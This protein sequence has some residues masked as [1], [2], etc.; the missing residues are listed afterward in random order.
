M[1]PR[2]RYR[3]RIDASSRNGKIRGLVHVRDGH[4]FTWTTESDNLFD[5]DEFN[6]I[7][8]RIS[9]WFKKPEDSLRAAINNQV[10]AFEAEAGRDDPRPAPFAKHD[11]HARYYIERLRGQGRFVRAGDSTFFF[12]AETRMPVNVQAGDMLGV[13]AGK[14]P[15]LNETL[16]VTK[17]VL[18]E[19]KWLPTGGL[20]EVELRRHSHYDPLK[21]ELVLDMGAGRVLKV[22]G[23][24]SPQVI[25]NGTEG[26]MFRPGALEEPW[27]YKPDH[28]VVLR[29][30][31]I[32][33]LNFSELED[34]PFTMEEQRFL[35]L[36]WMLSFWFRSTMPA[37]PLIV[38]Y[39]HSGSGK[40]LAMEHV[41]KL[42]IGPKFSTNPPPN[43]DDKTKI[44]VALVNRVFLVID[45]LDSYVKWFQDLVS[46]VVTGS[47]LAD[48]LLYENMKE[49][50]YAVDVILAITTFEPKHR[51]IDMASRS[52]FF[53]FQ[54]FGDQ[55]GEKGQGKNPLELTA[56]ILESRD[57]ILS[58]LVDLANEVLAVPRVTEDVNFRMAGF[59]QFML[60]VAD[61]LD[62]RAEQGRGLRPSSGRSWRDVVPGIFA[63]QQA[64]QQEFTSEADPL[65]LTLPLWLDRTDTPGGV[66]NAGRTVTTSELLK[67]LAAVAKENSV[68]FDIR[69]PK[70]LTAHIAARRALLGA[71]FHIEGPRRGGGGRGARTGFRGGSTYR[72]WHVNDPDAGRELL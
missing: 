69:S 11:V 54:K 37:R 17:Y 53:L 23:K 57:D 48:R 39:G 32:D 18:S 20:E 19:L 33:G 22:D 63:K 58:E 47:S 7:A 40:T 44:E 6:R 55:E 64:Y 42:L 59:N 66:L 24:G 51:R 61:G 68:S 72:I 15:E 49:G 30:K 5:P 1:P 50:Y 43:K 28:E 8:D 31:L 25:D 21:N 41:G 62:R 56:D 38:A 67:E 65:F 2:T 45:N 14:F 36:G 60:R 27:T 16:P 29:S 70:S 4:E 12:D 9:E 71:A 34:C 26:V 52:L 13:L 10:A 3:I 46:A 35:F